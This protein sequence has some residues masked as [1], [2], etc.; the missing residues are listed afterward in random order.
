MRIV[1]LYMLYNIRSSNV[2]FY[3]KKTTVPLLKA[4]LKAYL[5]REN[6]KMIRKDFSYIVNYL[7]IKA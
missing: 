2:V 7:F 4:N 1:Y 5:Q 3:I 6:K